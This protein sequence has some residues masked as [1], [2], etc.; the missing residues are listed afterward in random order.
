MNTH[1]Y[2]INK[3]T[4]C[5]KQVHSVQ[6]H[7][8]LVILDV[9]AHFLNK[10]GLNFQCSIRLLLSGLTVTLSDLCLLQMYY[11]LILMILVHNYFS[12]YCQENGC[13]CK[14]ILL[15]LFN[16]L[17]SG[18]I[19]PHPCCPIFGSVSFTLC[20]NFKTFIVNVKLW[21]QKLNFFG[22]EGHLPCDQPV[23]VYMLK[24]PRPTCQCKN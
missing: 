22:K 14:S 18:L 17:T 3:I 19:M 16:S 9:K 4:I 15:K 11:K 21:S 7:S 12:L 24:L 10:I 13:R 8:H 5:W 1:F 23:G 20:R 2:L 6:L